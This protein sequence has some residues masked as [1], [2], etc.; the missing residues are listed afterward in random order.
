MLLVA[1]KILQRSHGP[2]IWCT[3]IMMNASVYYLGSAAH[4]GWSE[5]YYYI[6][7][8]GN[9]SSDCQ[10]YFALEYELKQHINKYGRLLKKSITHYYIS[11]IDK[12]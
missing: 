4:R 11:I 6:N 5:E 8:I 1:L 2:D 3:C 12:L 10:I 9:P 7:E